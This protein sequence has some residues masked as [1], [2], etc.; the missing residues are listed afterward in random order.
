MTDLLYNLLP[1]LYRQMDAHQDQPLRALMAVLESEYRQLEEDIEVMY[2]NWFIETCDLWV[3]PYLADL[4]GIQHLQDV[5]HIPQQRRLI[6]NSIAYRRRKGTLAVLEQVIRDAT[7]WYARGVEFSQLVANSQHTAHPQLDRGQT[8]DVRQ[9]HGGARV[10]QALDALAHTIDVD[11]RHQV[12]Y[13]V[14][15]I[16]IFL[17]RLRSYPVRRSSAQPVVG[18]ASCFKFD[19][20]ERDIALFNQPQ[21]VVHISQRTQPVN[22][23]L[24][25]SRADLAADLHEYRVL[26]GHHNKSDQPAESRYYG[27]DRSLHI[28]WPGG[29]PVIKPSAV[30]S[31]DLS[32]WPVVPSLPARVVAAVDV[33]LGRIA[34]VDH[35]HLPDQGEIDIDQCSLLINKADWPSYLIVSY[36]VVFSTELGGGSYHREIPLPY[37]AEP[38][39]EINVAMGAA[40]RVGDGGVPGCVPTLGEAL[41][42]WNNQEKPRGVIRILDNGVYAENLTINLTKG[43]ILSILAGPG[44]R[45]I[46][47][48][49]EHP[50]I[51]IPGER[52]V[53]KAYPRAEAERQLPLT[54]RQLYLNGL[55][56][57]G[58]LQIESQAQSETTGRLSVT[59]EHCTLASSLDGKLNLAPLQCAQTAQGLDL[60]IE[61][62]FIGPL[63]LPAAGEDSLENRVRLRYAIVDNGS[64]YAI[65]ADPSGACPGPDV[66]L[67]RTT[68]FG[69]VHA[70]KLS[71]SEVIFTSPLQAPSAA[72][73]DQ[74]LYSY[75][76]PGST[77]LRGKQ[78]PS[79]SKD[80]PPPSFSATQYGDPAY[81][82]LSLDCPR[83]I[84]GG[85]ADGSEMGV[86]H[87]LYQLLAE[88]NLRQVLEEYLPLGLHASIHFV[89]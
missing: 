41:D 64:D 59:I 19:P 44:V 81:A 4:L 17:H 24:H 42:Y 78:H 76:P 72:A 60:N 8:V 48:N 77:T 55:F 33:E 66:H 62:S 18:S 28:E 61:R 45:P 73:P 49:R 58:G 67:E 10:D 85:A 84:R 89:T 15:R 9:L 37:P 16:G 38:V 79:I 26:Y 86:F 23:P 7:G 31:M 14:D 21:P 12:R 56:L 27:L 35:Q 63:Y 65:A 6:A 50:V 54:E 3:L 2:D 1:E 57:N 22:L 69:R 47:G 46:V 68:V 70:Q 34:F 53:F 75:V 36:N 13:N 51:V 82:Q 11:N 20:F 32:H 5:N 52:P 39:F 80:S 88:E 83:H 29:H 71:A 74:I 30:V 43:R 87:D 40:H 25:I